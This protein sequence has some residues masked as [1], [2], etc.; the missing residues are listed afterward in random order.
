MK[1]EFDKKLAD[2]GKEGKMPAL[3]QAF[4]LHGAGNKSKPAV[5]HVSMFKWDYGM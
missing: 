4:Y 5:L 3:W 1:H 2:K